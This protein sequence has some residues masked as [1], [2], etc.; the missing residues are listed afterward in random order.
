MAF[1]DITAAGQ[2]HDR[3]AL[4]KSGEYYEEDFAPAV[5]RDG[6]VYSINNI[7]CG[8][9]RWN[10]AFRPIKSAKKKGT[11]T[12]DD[13]VDMNSLRVSKRHGRQYQV[14]ELVAKHH[15]LRAEQDKNP[16]A[17]EGLLSLMEWM[18]FTKQSS[19]SMR[20]YLM[21][22]NKDKII[23]VYNSAKGSTTAF[24]TDF[25]HDVART[26]EERE[27]IP[28]GYE[29]KLMK[30]L[31]V[32]KEYKKPRSRLASQTGMSDEEKQGI[33]DFLAL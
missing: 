24:A 8:W 33:L 30:G 28:E 7:S 9:D 16:D 26:K 3:F 12:W 32:P 15:A 5:K 2:E 20:M 22:T 10:K 14:A 23:N 4:I 1:I 17:N 29:Y 6:S 11:Y 25:P 21:N 27:L 18:G 19:G 31:Q 13:S